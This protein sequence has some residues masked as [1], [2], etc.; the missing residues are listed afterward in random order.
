MKA[1][2]EVMAMDRTLEGALLKAIRSLEIGVDYL[3][4]D[5][6]DNQSLYDIRCLLHRIDDERLFVIAEA[7]AEGL[8]RKKSTVL[9]NGICSLF[10]KYRILSI[11]KDA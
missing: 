11:W 4:L 6:L 1:T 10:I 2:G 5:K 9:P 8:N 7:S 3:H